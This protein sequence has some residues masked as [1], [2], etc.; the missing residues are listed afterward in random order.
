MTFRRCFESPLKKLV[1]VSP[2]TEFR[3]ARR[4][5]IGKGNSSDEVTTGACKTAIL[6]RTGKPTLFEKPD[7]SELIA[8]R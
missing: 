1:R 8:T 7:A 4:C 5:S 6:Q 3:L 2:R